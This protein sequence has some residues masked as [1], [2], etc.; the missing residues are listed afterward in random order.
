MTAT[1]NHDLEQYLADARRLL[2]IPRPHAP[3]MRDE[4]AQRD[5]A[6]ELWDYLGDF[7]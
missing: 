5:F 3:E 2:T 6:T 1:P 4:E 7:A